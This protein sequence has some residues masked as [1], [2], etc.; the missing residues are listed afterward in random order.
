VKARGEAEEAMK[1][2]LDRPVEIKTEIVP[3]A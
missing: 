1:L 3:E 2:G